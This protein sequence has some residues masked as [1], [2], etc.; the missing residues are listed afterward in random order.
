MAW[1]KRSKKQS[2]PED[3]YSEEEAFDP[4]EEDLYT[5]AEWEENSYDRGESFY[6]EETNDYSTFDEG[7]YQDY[8][9]FEDHSEAEEIKLS[10]QEA[11]KE[12]LNYGGQDQSTQS[13]PQWEDSSSRQ[14]RPLRARYSASIDRFL[15]NGILVVAVLLILVLVIAFLL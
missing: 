12:Y 9:D 5:P 15:N 7:I 3:Y 10:S 2:Q 8:S 1:F 6:N 4:N 13:E 14:V 11:Y